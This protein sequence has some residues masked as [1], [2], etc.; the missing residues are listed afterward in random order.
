MIEN[1]KVRSYG[2]ESELI[3]KIQNEELINSK[4]NKYIGLW[5]IYNIFSIKYIEIEDRISC[6][7]GCFY[8]ISYHA[9]R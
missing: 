7:I 9:K 4:H 2:T 6:G 8:Q 1:L 3:I 5:I